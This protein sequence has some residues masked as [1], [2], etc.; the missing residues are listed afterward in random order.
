MNELINY[1]VRTNKQ[2][3]QARGWLDQFDSVITTV[4]S[5]H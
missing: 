1:Q 5:I 2:N 4:W 3:Q